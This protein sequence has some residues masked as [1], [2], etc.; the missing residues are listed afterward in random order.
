MAIAYFPD[1][2]EDEL[3]YSLFSRFY[4]HTGQTVYRD[5]AGILFQVRSTSPSIEFVNKLTPEVYDIITKNNNMHALI[6]KHTMFP[7]YMRFYD[8][9]R[10]KKSFQA[11]IE[12]DSSKN[13]F[14]KITYKDEGRYLRYCPLCA[15]EDRRIY[16]E[17]YWHRSHQLY[18]ND[19]CHIHRCY[20]VDSK[21]LISGKVSPDLI[22]AEM[23]V[24][25]DENIRECNDLNM[26]AL[27]QYMT[28]VFKL[29][30]DFE[31]NFPYGK[32]LEARLDKKYFSSDGIQRK[33]AVLHQEY[34]A[35]Y[36]SM[37]QQYLLTVDQM[38]KIF[39]GKRR[40]LSDICQMALFEKI[41][42]SELVHPR[43]DIIIQ[44]HNT[45]YQNVAHKLDIPYE[46][47][48]LVGN[49][50]MLEENTRKQNTIKEYRAS[51][52]WERL[53]MELIP[54]VKESIGFI[55]ESKAGRPVKITIASVCR[56]I[57][58]PDK[59]FN[60]LPK[61]KEII[62]SYYESQEHF[63][64]RELIWA[65]QTILND[66]TTLNWKH[67]RMLT[68]L[69]KVNVEASLTELKN[70]DKDICELVEALL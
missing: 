51:E 45:I 69:R 13:I 53:D 44:T 54:K 55:Q 3:L 26:I 36:A 49:A 64:A 25:P 30:M 61:C 59:K 27:S 33:M 16:G 11:L 39:S 17:T 19:I 56:V 5:T 20:L 22:A 46:T 23:E 28:E 14:P 67:I 52:K 7:M 57:G 1:I 29:D 8:S 50:I 37:N 32:Y 9:D 18:G 62:E 6:E 41:P 43:E 63:W 47:V 12:M 24:E 38:H 40:R 31:K 65:V 42:I 68:N 70:M 15:K 48:E 21:V 35:Y 34:G 58:F 2:Y 66:N 4:A 10:R 60:S